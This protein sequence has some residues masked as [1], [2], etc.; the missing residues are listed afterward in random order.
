MQ[1]RG[2]LLQ[3]FPKTLYFYMEM[4]AWPLRTKTGLQLAVTSWRDAQLH[5]VLV[6]QLALLCTVAIINVTISLPV[7]SCTLVTKSLHFNHS[8]A[9]KFCGSLCEKL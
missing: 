6:Q 9:E 1:T 4:F 3:C 8:A 2:A 7:T 5:L